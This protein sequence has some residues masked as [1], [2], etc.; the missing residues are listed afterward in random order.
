[1]TDLAQTFETLVPILNEAEAYYDRKDYKTDR[2]T[3]GKALHARL[4]PAATAFLAA[5]RRLDDAQE[6]LKSGL[7]RQE[8]ARIERAEG[9]SVRWHTK[10]T[11]TLAKTAVEKMPRDPHRAAELPAFDAAVAAFADAVR[12][13]D[14]AVAQS[15]KS[16][17]IDSFPRG[18]LGKMR[19]LRDKVGDRR[20]QPQFYAMDFN[21]IVSQYNMMI[22][23]ANAFR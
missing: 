23:M 20:T 13:F 10:R 1:M 19:D 22:G 2:M 4:V 3:G 12:E 14:A 7:D 15:G 18:L 5:R 11:I 9:K 16:G 8:L 17:T 21:N 6:Q